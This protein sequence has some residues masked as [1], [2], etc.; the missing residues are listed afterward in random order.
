[1]SFDR[2]T[3]KSSIQVIARAAAI[4]RALEGSPRGLSLGQIAKK[5]DLPRSTVQRIV[6]ALNR[7]HLVLTSEKHGIR[8]GPAL[9][10]FAAATRYP[11]LDVAKDTL[12]ALSN[13][14][15]E[16]VDLSIQDNDSMVFIHQVLGKQR[17]TAT[18]SI[19]I[20]F[21]LY[22]SANG[23]AML[24]TFSESELNSFQRKSAELIPYTQNTIVNWDAL[25]SELSE[26]RTSRIA[27]DREEQ[28]VGIC[29]VSATIVTPFGEKAA[30]SIP[31]PTQ[32]FIAREVEFS[33]ALLHHC[34]RLQASINNS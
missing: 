1:M 29:A 32:R 26:I 13:E 9:S 7:E 27:K 22:S 6:D 19:G 5:V 18:S 31:V 16:T 21:P 3:S 34:E 33:S 14:L 25:K 8:L 20:A 17:L 24:A 28:S 4:L 11:V 23:K 15:G 10:V 30:I 2:P 12:E